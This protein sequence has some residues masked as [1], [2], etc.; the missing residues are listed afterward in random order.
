MPAT[1]IRIIGPFPITVNII[2]TVPRGNHQ[3][4]GD[5]GHK[6]GEGEADLAGVGFTR[7][8]IANDGHLHRD[9]PYTTHKIFL[10]HRYKVHKIFLTHK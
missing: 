7:G 6:G 10:A 2:R 9:R 4:I 3:L 8:P 5:G 1:E